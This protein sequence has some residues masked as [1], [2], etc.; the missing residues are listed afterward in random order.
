[1][2]DPCRINPSAQCLVDNHYN[3][4][5]PFLSPAAAAFIDAGIIAGR[6]GNNYYTVTTQTLPS[7]ALSSSAGYFYESSPLNTS[8]DIIAVL[9]DSIESIDR[10]DI[11]PTRP[12]EG[13]GD[14]QWK[15]AKNQTA[16]YNKTHNIIMIIVII[17]VTIQTIIQ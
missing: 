16:D 8:D 6:S 15:I 9:L 12:Y 2:A 3:P 5:D 7:V 17:V 11:R 10:A 13:S 1:M 4:P 14:W